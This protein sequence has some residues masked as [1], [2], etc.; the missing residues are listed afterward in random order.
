MANQNIEEQ[1]PDI[2]FDLTGGSLEVLIHYDRAS[3]KFTVPEKAL[4]VR[5][6]NPGNRAV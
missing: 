2:E 4:T 1:I 3:Q 6:D 5:S